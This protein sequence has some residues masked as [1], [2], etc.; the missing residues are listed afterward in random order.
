MRHAVIRLLELMIRENYE[1]D[2]FYFSDEPIDWLI[3]DEHYYKLFVSMISELA[4]RVSLRIVFPV[5][6]VLSDSFTNLDVLLPI[7]RIANIPSYFCPKYRRKESA[8]SP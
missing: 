4:G 6:S 3:E 2:V 7:Y 8:R 1:G 5:S